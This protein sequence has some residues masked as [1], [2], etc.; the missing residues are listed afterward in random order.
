MFTES[1]I[2]G[3]ELENDQDPLPTQ[4]AFSGIARLRWRRRR[5]RPVCTRLHFAQKRVARG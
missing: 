3:P 5:L 4:I 2:L 1:L